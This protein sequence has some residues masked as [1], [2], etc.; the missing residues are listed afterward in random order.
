MTKSC[1]LNKKQQF[2]LNDRWGMSHFLIIFGP[3]WLVHE[4]HCWRN[5]HEANPLGP[6]AVLHISGT[7]N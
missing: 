5:N 4:K 3:D 7:T 6:V 1:I 2:V